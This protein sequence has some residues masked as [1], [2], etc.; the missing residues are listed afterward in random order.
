MEKERPFEWERERESKGS[1]SPH[2]QSSATSHAVTSRS[3]R[4][5][6]ETNLPPPEEMREE[7]RNYTALFGLLSS[8]SSVLEDKLEWV[9]AQSSEWLESFARWKLRTGVWERERDRSSKVLFLALKVSS[10]RTNDHFW[11][12]IGNTML[13]FLSLPI[14]SPNFPSHDTLLANFCIKSCH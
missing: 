12:E 10:R 13:S 6:S 2:I 1:D 11:R 14:L 5:S 4:L 3:F 7:L 8:S 9:A